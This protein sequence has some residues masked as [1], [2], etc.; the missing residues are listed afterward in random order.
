MNSTTT[1]S[2]TEPRPSDDVRNICVSLK[3]KLGFGNE[4]KNS[5]GETRGTN[6]G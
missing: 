3:E 2:Y 6:K 4:N 1:E 5:G